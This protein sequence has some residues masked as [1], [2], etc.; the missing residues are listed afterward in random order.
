M[1]D[2]KKRS[3]P[4]FPSY[5]ETAVKEEIHKC[6]LKEIALARH[7]IKGI[8]GGACGGD[9]LFHELCKNMHVQSEMYLALPIKD[10]KK[11]SVSFAGNNWDLRFDKLAKELPV[12]ILP[13]A[14]ED[15]NDGNVWERTNLWMLDVAL[16][17]SG[18]NTTLMALWD[19]KEGDGD[20]G[21]KHMITLA[22]QRGAKIK[23]IDITKI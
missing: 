3:E 4:R 22:K 8:A 12:H 18:K 11:A 1:I 2:A 23:M 20:G 5:K 15:S 10:F 14:K 17:N 19:G 13:V 16:K 7:D 6:L 9:I 21:T